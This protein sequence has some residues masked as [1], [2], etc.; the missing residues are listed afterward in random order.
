ML[1]TTEYPCL[2]ICCFGAVYCFIPL[3]ALWCGANYTAENVLSYPES[4]NLVQSAN[5]FHLASF[6]V[7]I[8]PAADILLDIPHLAAAYFRS[9]DKSIG[10]RADSKIMR[11]SES[12]R[13]IFI[14]GIALQSTPS[15]LSSKTDFAVSLL[16][17]TCANNSS[18][19]LILAPIVAFLTRSTETFTR[20]R[21]NLLASI[22]TVAYLVLTTSYFFPD[23]DPTQAALVMTNKILTYITGFLYSFLIY[24]CAFK[25]F[26]EK[27]R[28]KSSR[29]AYYRMLFKPTQFKSPQTQRKGVEGSEELDSEL[30][31]NYIPALH[32]IS[33]VIIIT[34]SFAVALTPLDRQQEA[35]N[36]KDFIVLFSQIMVLVI[37]LRI[38]KNEVARGLVSI[39][40]VLFHP[41]LFCPVPLHPV[42]S[43]PILSHH[44][45]SHS[46]LSHSIPCHSILSHSI[47]SHPIPFYLC[48]LR[49]LIFPV[50]FLLLPP[51]R[52][53][54]NCTTDG[55]S[56][57]Q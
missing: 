34:A 12:E 22:I 23:T 8:I 46:I 29:S 26:Y 6:F 49:S 2:G 37:E 17:Q 5:L 42:L 54:Y 27:L 3:V 50:H 48:V 10:R 47:P 30:Y 57:S 25:Y 35:Y 4:R 20:N 16:V 45:L 41:I 52:P 1:L 14:L 19:L 21:T 43:Y 9:S 28:T 32:M 40:P 56:L 38:R 18:T 7:T 11:L 44:I 31:T 33:T 36:N 15:F 13:F 39:C 51:S 55:S 24:Y 53:H